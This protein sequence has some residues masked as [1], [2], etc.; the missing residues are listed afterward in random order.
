[1]KKD[2]IRKIAALAAC[3]AVCA[4]A[5]CGKV[6]SNDN[7]ENITV[8]GND[9]SP[10]DA[11]EITADASSADA[12]EISTIPVGTAENTS[13]TATNADGE[14]IPV[15]GQPSDENKSQAATNADGAGIPV[16]GQPTDENISQETSG[17]AAPS[18][19]TSG[20]GSGSE[21]SDISLTFYKVTLPVGGS[22][23][24]IVTMFPETAEN[25]NEIW[26][27][28]DASVATVD[29]IGNIKAV[30]EGICIITVKSVDNPSVSASVEVTV[31]AAPEAAV[32]DGVTYIDGIL[33]ANKTYALPASYNPGGLTNECY[34]AFMNLVSGAAADNIN[35]YCSSGFRSYESQQY[36][37]NNY[38]AMDGQA[39]ADTYSAR[40]GHSEHQTGLA[41]DCNIIDD[42]FTGTP[43]AIWLENNCHKYGFIIRYPKNKSHI[44]GYKYEPW[45][46]RYIG[47]EKATAVY[48]SGLCLEEYLGITSHYTY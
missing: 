27:S 29:S 17:T 15:S 12:T 38:V 22:K 33:I 42:S 20:T 4:G 19:N 30:G 18:Q 28:S 35:I 9:S 2:I 1:M 23:M 14:K 37:Y 25:K 39:N 41:I 11:S 48:N 46:I 32:A 5:S 8:S 45:H 16:S 6:K 36:I 44:T 31:E 10:A 43:E 40:P 24:P 47:V 13:Q 34:S 21:V 7:S 26:T 3:F